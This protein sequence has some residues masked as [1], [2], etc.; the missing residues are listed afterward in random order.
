MLA[1][2][3]AEGTNRRGRYYLR[4]GREGYEYIGQ[5]LRQGWRGALKVFVGGVVSMSM[6]LVQCLI[7]LDLVLS[8]G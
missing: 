2:D 8:S 3:V 5:G 4:D 7:F 6:L 1:Q